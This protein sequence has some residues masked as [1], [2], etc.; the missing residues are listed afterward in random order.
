M[1]DNTQESKHGSREIAIESESEMAVALKNEDHDHE[2]WQNPINKNELKF[3]A[4]ESHTGPTATS[5]HLVGKIRFTLARVSAI[6]TF[7][8]TFEAEL[9]L[10][11][12]FEG[13]MKQHPDFDTDTDF[14]F[15]F[16]NKKGELSELERNTAINGDDVEFTLRVAGDFST[17]FDLHAFPLD[18]QLLTINFTCNVPCSSRTSKPLLVDLVPEPSQS[19][20]MLAGFKSLTNMWEPHRLD[21]LSSKSNINESS[22]GSVYSRM[23]LILNVRR[24]PGWYNWNVVCPTYVITLLAAAC[25]SIPIT[26]SADRLSNIFTLLLTAAAYKIVVSSKLPDIPYLTRL[27]LYVLFSFLFMVLLCIESSVF[28]F[29]G[30]G[31][32]HEDRI[33]YAVWV[34]VWNIATFF[35]IKPMIGRK[36]CHNRTQALTTLRAG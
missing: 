30:E 29:L 13:L 22:S 17:R 4:R 5:K 31:Y 12:V 8:Q 21:L 1:V 27:D 18:N 25:V 14:Q 6:D 36:H 7:L 19:L 10:K 20:F 33:F 24:L 32:E 35:I 3:E 15:C 23:D 2:L 9:Y 34:G 26:E 11:C 28:A 16:I